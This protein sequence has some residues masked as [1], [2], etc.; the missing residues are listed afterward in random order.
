MHTGAERPSGQPSDAS[1]I[2]LMQ[3][4]LDALRRTIERVERQGDQAEA[5]ATAA[6]AR[7]EALRDRRQ[8]ER[9]LG[10]ALERG[11]FELYF[12]P[13]LN[14]K[15]QAFSGFEA[16]LR[17]HHPEQGMISPARLS[18]ATISARMSRISR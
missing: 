8:L 1:M 16:L 9:D 15:R 3:E 6:E 5:R 18:S 10:V 7:A 11:E 4:A 2:E 14:L 13:I 12:Q 17:W